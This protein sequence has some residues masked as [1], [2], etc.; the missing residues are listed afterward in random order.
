MGEHEI[1]PPVSTLAFRILLTLSDGVKH[2]YS[3]SKELEAS[4]DG[5]KVRFGTLYG[6][7]KQMHTD[8]WIAEV[9][10]PRGD[11]PRRRY[12]RLTARGRRV[13]QAEAQRLATLV[14]EARARKMLPYAETS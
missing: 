2:G 4:F 8:G 10:S 14:R 1:E 5:L 3:I 6:L 12:Y 9:E 7:L 11:D 13:G